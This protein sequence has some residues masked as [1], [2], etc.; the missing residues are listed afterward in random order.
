MNYINVW[1]NLSLSS[2][3]LSKYFALWY[4]SSLGIGDIWSPLFWFEK[5]YSTGGAYLL[6]HLSL[7][8]AICLYY[9][10]I[11]LFKTSC[12]YSYLIL[13]QWKLPITKNRVEKNNIKAQMKMYKSVG[14]Y[15][16]A[17]GMNGYEILNVKQG[18]T[19]EFLET[20]NEHW[21]KMRSISSGKTGLVPIN[22]LEP[23]QSHAT[24]VRSNLIKIVAIQY[25]DIFDLL[26]EIYIISIIVVVDVKPPYCLLI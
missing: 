26:L 2:N 14:N 9:K 8:L 21:W 18:E 10:N 5:Y 22:Y 15:S 1:S 23:I 20:C 16:P 4:S 24:M 17:K 11:G 3:F 12:T 13:K 25:L 6:C 7:K 19:Y